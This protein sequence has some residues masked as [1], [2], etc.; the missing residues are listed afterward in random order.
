MHLKNVF[1]VT[2]L[3]WSKVFKELKKSNVLHVTNKNKLKQDILTKTVNSVF[4]KYLSLIF[5]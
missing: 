2:T 1:K 3:W 5:H 4:V